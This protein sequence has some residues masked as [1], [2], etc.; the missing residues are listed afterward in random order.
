VLE[1][2]ERVG[3]GV[4]TAGDLQRDEAPREIAL[5]GQVYAAKCSAAQ[6]IHEVEA[7]ELGAHIGQRP[8]DFL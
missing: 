8:G 5:P 6:L 1:L 4:K 7:D 3:L 2:R